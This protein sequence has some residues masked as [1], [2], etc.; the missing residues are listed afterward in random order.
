VDIL[1]ATTKCF[2]LKI[3]LAIQVDFATPLVKATYKLEGD[4]FLAL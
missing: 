4:G 1:D 3:E 2:Q